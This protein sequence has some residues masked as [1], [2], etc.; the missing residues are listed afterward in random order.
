MFW[1]III[2]IVLFLPGFLFFSAIPGESTLDRFL[3]KVFLSRVAVT[4][5]LSILISLGMRNEMPHQ[6]L[7]KEWR[8]WHIVLLD[9][10]FDES[11]TL[12]LLTL[13]Y[14]LIK[15]L[16]FGITV[17]AVGVGGAI[18][19]ATKPFGTWV[20][21]EQ[22][23]LLHPVACYGYAILSVF[24]ILQN[25]VYFES[26]ITR[27]TERKEAIRCYRSIRRRYGDND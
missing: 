6:S 9:W 19:L 22:Y 8:T 25:R 23:L 20:L 14:A 16:L 10:A 21:N 27:L 1:L 18:I 13:Q 2:T 5:V 12:R 15:G 24:L 4:I 7:S 17:S 11:V 26:R 3:Y